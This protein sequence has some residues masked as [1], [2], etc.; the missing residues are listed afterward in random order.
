MGEIL[1]LE[2]ELELDRSLAY[3]GGL[4]LVAGVAGRW[5]AA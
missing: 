5:M 4:R 1:G 3:A 2:L